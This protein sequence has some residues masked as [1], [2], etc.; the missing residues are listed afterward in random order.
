MCIIYFAVVTPIA[1]LLKVFNKDILSLKKNKNV[2]Y[3]KK[4]EK[5]NTNMKNQF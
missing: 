1:L 5:Y 4:K 2:S 3:W